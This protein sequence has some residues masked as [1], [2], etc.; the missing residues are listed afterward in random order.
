M[1]PNHPKRPPRWRRNR[2]V[3]RPLRPGVRRALRQLQRAHRLMEKGEYGQAA[4]LFERLAGIVER[5]A[6]AR[7]AQLYFEAG[8]ARLL[9]GAM[10]AGMQDLRQGVNLL[11][12]SGRY[13]LL[14]RVSHRLPEE[15]HRLG[16]VQAASELTG[17]MDELLEAV[18]SSFS[19][20]PLES[21]PTLPTKCPQC[22][23]TIHTREVE[24]LGTDR[25]ECSYCGSVVSSKA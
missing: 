22:G 11:A 25:A 3:Q 12:S 18:P 5:R 7:A 6:A 16:F 2:P 10:K 20:E 24:W 21:R 1:T 23:G 13:E 19:S 9:D 15:L 14:A 8:K 17:V 4:D